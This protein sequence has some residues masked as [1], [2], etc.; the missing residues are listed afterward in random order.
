MNALV[1]L[2]DAVEGDALDVRRRFTGLDDAD[3]VEGV[4][5]AVVKGEL[6]PFGGQER[7]EGQ[8]VDLDAESEQLFDEQAIHPGGGSGVPGPAAP[9]FMALGAVDVGGDDVGL[10]FVA[11]RLFGGIGVANGIEHREQPPGL[12]GPAQPGHGHDG[13]ERGM[14][15]LSAV[16]AHAGDV[17]AD[18]AGIQLV[19]VERRL[20]QADDGGV[21]IDQ[22][23]Q[24]GI[25]RLP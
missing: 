1:G 21:G 9:A 4:A 10:D 6:G 23:F 17:A 18:V 16:F 2:L 22:P 11:R 15:V 5:V 3:V 13:P 8:R 20:E 12:F 7:G 24:G 14:G 25:Q 19:A